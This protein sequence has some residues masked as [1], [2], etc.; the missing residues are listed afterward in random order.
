MT[1]LMRPLPIMLQGQAMRW[2]HSMESGAG[3]VSLL[4]SAPDVY[5]QL[6]NALLLGQPVLLADI[7]CELDAMME[8]LLAKA[9]TR[10]ACPPSAC[11]SPGAPCCGSVCMLVL[12]LRHSLLPD[13]PVMR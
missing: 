8:P 5:R 13:R 10:C 6:E 3:L 7:G 2:I 12:R 9:Y 11:S 1:A 4:P